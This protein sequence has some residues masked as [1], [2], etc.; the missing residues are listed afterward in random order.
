MI[1]HLYIS[2]NRK[3]HCFSLRI[4]SFFV[5]YLIIVRQ[6]TNIHLVQFAF[7]YLLFEVQCPHISFYWQDHCTYSVDNYFDTS[8]GQLQNTTNDN[9][10]G[11]LSIEKIQTDI[12]SRILIVCLHLDIASRF[13]NIKY[14]FFKFLPILLHNFGI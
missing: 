14:D 11:K 1:T 5:I 6:E 10:L 2:K 7:V 13:K 9:F 8:L 3:N 4:Y 12:A